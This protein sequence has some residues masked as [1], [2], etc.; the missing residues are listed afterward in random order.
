[1]IFLFEG[2]REYVMDVDTE[3][4]KFGVLCSLMEKKPNLHWSQTLIFC[5]S[6]NK[7]EGLVKEMQGKRY[8]VA[9]M[10]RIDLL[11]NFEI[12]PLHSQ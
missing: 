9:G 8:L 4:W 6:I 5:N 12:F 7:V 11:C 1:M 3:E 10:V 2:V